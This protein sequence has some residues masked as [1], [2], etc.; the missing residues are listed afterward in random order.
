MVVGNNQGIEPVNAK[1]FIV[2]WDDTLNASSWCVRKGIL[3]IRPPNEAEIAQVKEL[4]KHCALTLRT[5]LDHGNVVIVTNAESGWVEL[6][7]RQLMPEVAKYVYSDR[8]VSFHDID[9]YL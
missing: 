8:V 2:D 7:A 1:L 6:S 5:C 3:T 9:C 4:S